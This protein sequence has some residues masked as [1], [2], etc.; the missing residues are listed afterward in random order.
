MRTLSVVNKTDLNQVIV[1]ERK[2]F[3]DNIES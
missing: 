1:D 2:L 3:I